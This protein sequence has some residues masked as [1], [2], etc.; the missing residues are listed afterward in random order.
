MPGVPLFLL[1]II[2]KYKKIFKTQKWVLM[3]SI[4]VLIKSYSY[5]VY[6]HFITLSVFSLKS[7][8]L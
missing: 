5:S 7:V 2:Q 6:T 8:Q 3:I 4:K 1:M